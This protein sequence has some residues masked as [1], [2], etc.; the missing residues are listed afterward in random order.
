M[1]Q[2]INPSTAKTMPIMKRVLE[3]K[4]NFETTV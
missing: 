4:A 1:I 2:V 3:E